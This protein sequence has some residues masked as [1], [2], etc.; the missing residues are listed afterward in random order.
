MVVTVEQ[1]LLL[2]RIRAAQKDFSGSDLAYQGTLAA[3]PSNQFWS[4]VVLDDYAR[5]LRNYGRTKQANAVDKQ[6]SELR[7]ALKKDSSKKP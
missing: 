1:G 4:T 3:I 6:L 7:E 2:A 5:T